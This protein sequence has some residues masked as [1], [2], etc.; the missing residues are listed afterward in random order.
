MLLVLLWCGAA[1]AVQAPDLPSIALDTL[2][3]AART[4]IEQ[5]YARAR[6]HPADAAAAGE[7]GMVLH[8]YEQYASAEAAYRRA[9][10]LDARSFQW[11]YGLGV[12]Q[13]QTGKHADAVQSLRASLDLDPKY[14]PA[15][16]K[17]AE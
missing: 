10:A 8:A 6:Q 2:A 16:L 7:L 11:V 13:A 12:I 17:L 5:A 14:A 3:P 4:Q 1:L 9:R 15:R